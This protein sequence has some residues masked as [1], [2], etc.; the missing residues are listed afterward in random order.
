MKQPSKT[1]DE[2]LE[3]LF[4]EAAMAESLGGA[5]EHHHFALRDAKQALAEWIKSKKPQA[6]TITVNNFGTF[7]TDDDRIPTVDEFEQAL[8]ADLEEDGKV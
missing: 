4:D 2:I 3:L 5:G 1:I 6:G 7:I 8:L